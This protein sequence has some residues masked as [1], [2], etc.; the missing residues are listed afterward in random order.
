MREV[1][2]SG[3]L[4]EEADEISAAFAAHGLTETG[5]IG[6]GGWTGLRLSAV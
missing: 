5:R 1:V 2:L 3:L 4:D 6:E